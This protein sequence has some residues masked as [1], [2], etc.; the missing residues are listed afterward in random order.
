MGACCPYARVVLGC[1]ESNC[2]RRLRARVASMRVS[3]VGARRPPG[4]VARLC[5]SP[6]GVR[7]SRVVVARLCVSYVGAWRALWG[8]GFSGRERGRNFRGRLALLLPP[9]MGERDNGVCDGSAK[10]SGALA[11]ALRTYP[12]GAFRCGAR[13]FGA[14]YFDATYYAPRFGEN[15]RK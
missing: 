9:H 3:I 7:I 14:M 8:A 1:V 4:L 6:T 12:P 11:S 2:T 5:V 13:E 10:A 15:S